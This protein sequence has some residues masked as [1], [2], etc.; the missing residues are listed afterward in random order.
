[1]IEPEYQATYDRYV[2]LGA[3][4]AASSKLAIVA[5]ARNAMPY[6]ANTLLLVEE[7]AGRFRSAEFYVFEN[8]SADDTAEV[9]DAFAIRQWVTV[10]HATLGRE[11]MRM[12]EPERTVRLA[13][14]R[15][16]CRDW[17]EKNA[18]DAQYVCVLDMDPHGGFSVDGVL[19][20]LGWM[21]QKL[22]EINKN[23]EVGAMASYSLFCTVDEAGGLGLAQYD[24]WAARLNFW[25]DRRHKTG[26]MKWFHMLMPPV[27]SPPIPMNSAFGGLC[28]YTREAFLSGRYSGIGVT[29]EPDCE[30]VAFHKTMREAGH[31]LYL[32]PGSRYAA[33][34][35]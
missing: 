13:E 12:H 8:D 1:M 32:N 16:R 4:R 14:Y 31:Q 11:D 3:E 18:T 35:P 15:N 28:L 17:V 23:A 10:E 9:L 27:G 30:H 33:I 20:S 2:A 26:G 19:N 24:A 7:L 5:I 22:G 6:L 25:E 34:L 29:G 21:C